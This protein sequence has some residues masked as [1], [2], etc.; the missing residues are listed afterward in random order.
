MTSDLGLTGFRLVTDKVS[1]EDVS[2]R[3]KHIKD[4]ESWQDEVD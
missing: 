1:D 3:I 2:S 4:V